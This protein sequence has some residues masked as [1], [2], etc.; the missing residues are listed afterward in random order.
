MYYEYLAI[1]GFL[2]LWLLVAWDAFTELSGGRIRRLE[3]EERD[4][5][6]YLE[7]LKDNEQDYNI[8][9]RILIFAL[10]GVLLILLIDIIPQFYHGHSLPHL[11]TEATGII[12]G[13]TLISGI[14]FR[15]VVGKFDIHIIRFTFPLLTVIKY[16]ILFPV[17]FM[18][19][20]IAKSVEVR[21]Q[22]EDNQ[23][24]VTV[25]DEI[26]SLV[27]DDDDDGDE[28]DLEEDEKRMIRGIFDLDNTLVR[29]IMTPRVDMHS[30][31]ATVTPAQAKQEFISSGHSRIPIYG[32][33]IDEIK[34]VVYAKDF[35][36]DACRD[37]P[38]DQLAHAPVFIPETKNVGDLLEEFRL[39][40]IHFAIIIDEY[41]GTSGV[42]SLEDILEE[43]VGEI[44]DEYDSELDAEPKPKFM[45]DG[46]VVVDARTMID[47]V[48]ELLDIALT[49]D[50][51]V[52]T[53]AGYVCAE[54]GK[55]PEVGEEIVIDDKLHVTILAADKR[56]IISLNLKLLGKNDTK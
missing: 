52:D 43:I 54:F 25:E 36:D 14:V 26:M 4:L 30:L 37:K 48:N 51:D 42:V 17:V 10:F 41:G 8:V 50:E 45:P 28:G 13:L 1:A 44:Q 47:D 22:S 12:L 15:L 32:E 35:L 39:N 34:G 9:V 23:E 33:N 55:I 18:M 11:I 31:S 27:E 6:R 3:T 40:R 20:L 56:K 46:S 16:T 53:I 21:E 5:A 29:E 7:R 19:R 2:F 24:K 49:E 38:L